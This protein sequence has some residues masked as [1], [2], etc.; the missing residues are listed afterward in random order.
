MVMGIEEN[1]QQL[2]NDKLAD[3]PLFLV[4]VKML[5]S[6]EL[7]ILID[8]D[9]GVKVSDCVSLSRHISG[10][11]EER[12]IID[13]AYRIEV[14]SPGIG[15][16]LI[17]QRQYT[18]NIGRK[19]AIKLADTT[20]YEGELIATNEQDIVITIT[21]KEKGKKTTSIEKRIPYNEITEAKVLITF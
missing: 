1:I 14:S 9:E 12:N 10:I 20:T 3:S 5:P 6:H 4:E 13:H 17:L 8:G 7:K 21:L 2:V 15:F 16:P 11:I 18:K 19:L